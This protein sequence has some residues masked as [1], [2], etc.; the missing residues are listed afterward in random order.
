MEAHGGVHLPASGGGWR[1]P[2]WSTPG[3]RR[4]RFRQALRSGTRGRRRVRRGDFRHVPHQRQN[5]LGTGAAFFNLLRRNWGLSVRLRNHCDPDVWTTRRSRT[6]LA[7]AQC[8]PRR[9]GVV[10]TRH[11]PS[12]VDRWSRGSV[13]RTRTIRSESDLVYCLLF[14]ASCHCRRM[15]PSFPGVL[16]SRDQ[17][18]NRLLCCSELRHVTRPLLVVGRS[19]MGERFRGSSISGSAFARRQLLVD[20][21]RLVRTA[22]VPIEDAKGVPGSSGPFSESWRQLERLGHPCGF[23]VRPG[24]VRACPRDAVSYWT[25]GIRSG[26]S[27]AQSRA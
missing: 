2:P 18:G 12:S 6:S 13:L 14:R 25:L 3:G 27:S 11:R 16:V 9:Q 8:Q 7:G 22:A 24:C 26:S 10:R 5:V 23:Q 1:R 20:W 4:P 17:E 19:S 21:A 15:C